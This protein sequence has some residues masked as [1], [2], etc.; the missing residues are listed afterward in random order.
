MD[1]PAAFGEL[2][3]QV[4]KGDQ[5]AAAELVRI[6]EPTI[7]RVV[8]LRLANAPLTAV[9][10]STDICQSVLASFFVRVNLG[11][12]SLDTP[13][14]LVKLLATMARSKL[15][16]QVRREQAQRRDRRRTVAAADDQQLV[17]S[18]ATPSRQVAARD[19]L[20]HVR[21]RLSPD[22]RALAELR[23]EGRDWAAVADQLGGSPDALRMK[24]TRA[25]DRVARELGVEDEL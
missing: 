12:Y 13:E 22:E 2:L 19:L 17:G 6:Y 18:V 9:L 25:I 21:R 4:R 10:D 5:D 7:R 1:L 16:A 3:A 20:D 11:Q 23:H 8:R 24:L 15:A 14:Q